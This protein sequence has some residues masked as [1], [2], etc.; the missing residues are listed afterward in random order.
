MQDAI[1]RRPSH[2]ERLVARDR[3]KLTAI[4]AFW[5]R[6]SPKEGIRLLQG[7]VTEYPDDAE[8]WWRLGEMEFH[9]GLRTG[10]PIDE[11][12]ATLLRSTGLDSANAVLIERRW[13]A[14]VEEDQQEDERL[15]RRML[16]QA[17]GADF[18][19]L[20]RVDVALL[21][22]D[23]VG[24]LQTIERVRDLR[25][26]IRLLY[27]E[28]VAMHTVDTALLRSATSLLTSAD[29]APG[30]RVAGYKIMAHALAACGHWRS[31]R[32]ELG[33]MEAVD[34]GAAVQS[35]GML[36]LHSSGATIHCTEQGRRESPRRV[37]SLCTA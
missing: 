25:G 21:S 9:H 12:R 26:L 32:R 18:H 2:R 7:V 17:P 15:S 35:L 30:M 34:P 23:R 24:A 4:D 36:S 13:L 14:N 5:R 29:N 19:P 16:A 33:A 3:A 6:R 10:R 28:Q 22:G 1:E 31:A 27:V 20:L 8:A 11:I 37:D